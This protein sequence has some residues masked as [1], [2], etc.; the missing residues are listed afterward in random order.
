MLTESVRADAVVEAGGAAAGTGRRGRR[1]NPLALLVGYLAAVFFVAVLSSAM[2]AP[3]IRGWYAGLVKPGFNPPNAIFGPVW[4]VLYV[5]MALAAWRVAMVT[6]VGERHAGWPARQSALFFWWVQLAL[7]FAWSVLFFHM[8]RV[9]GALVDI[10]LLLGAVT[11]VTVMFWRISRTAGLML[12]PYLLW[13]GF[14]LVLNLRIF[15]LN[16]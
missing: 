10:V 7:N 4:T 16:G 14:A 12:L 13:T 8:H 15:Q 5:L 3:A 9:G 6:A 11:V 2:T 1:K